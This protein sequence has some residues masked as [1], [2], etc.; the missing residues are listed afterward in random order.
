MPIVKKP[1]VR[2]PR[3]AKP[4]AIALGPVPDNIEQV[5]IALTAMKAYKHNTNCSSYGFVGVDNE[6][7]TQYN[8]PCHYSM[9]HKQTKKDLSVYYTMFKMKNKQLATRLAEWLIGDNSPWRELIKLNPPIDVDGTVINTLPFVLEHGYIFYNLNTPA[10]LLANWSIASRSE[11]EYATNVETMFTLVDAGVHPS[12]AY[13]FST[14]LFKDGDGWRYSA[15]DH[16]HWCLNF[17]GQDENYITNFVTGT[18]V[19]PLAMY[20]DKQNYIPCNTVWGKGV[21][22][23]NTYHKFLT[24]EYFEQVQ[25][26]ELKTEFGTRKAKT[27]TTDELV[28]ILKREAKRIGVQ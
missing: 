22:G 13:F 2:K 11:W 7:V 14:V 1:A 10:N 3:V 20:K 12:I 9:G 18:V 15:R 25:S 26:K 17:M 6:L 8:Q 23:D 27:M 28:G 24:K 5:R 19:Q 16:G 4:K 21:S